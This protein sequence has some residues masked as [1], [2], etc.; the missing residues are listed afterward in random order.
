MP[1]IKNHAP[2]WVLPIGHTWIA[3]HIPHQGSMCLLD[4]VE[5][6]DATRIICRAQSHLS[7]D[8]P[9]R[10]EGS[11]GITNG[12]EYA[13]QAMAVHG[14]LLAATDVTPAAGFITSVRSV[15]WNRLRLD[16]ID[17]ELEVSAERLSGNELNILYEFSLLCANIVLLSGRASVILDAAGNRNLFSTG[18][19]S[20]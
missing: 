19:K 3:A 14:A 17:G 7:P 10:H 4:R 13:A 8:N 9:L 11:L 6:W 20:S 2:S 18:D 12:I 16:D 1:P 5:F 15:R